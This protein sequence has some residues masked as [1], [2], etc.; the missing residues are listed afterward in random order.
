MSTS[1]KIYGSR[2]YPFKTS[3][4]EGKRD[5][6]EYYTL[7]NEKTQRLEVKDK[8]LTAAN[9]R[10]VGYYDLSV[11]PPKFVRSSTFFARFDDKKE[12]EFFSSEDGLKQAQTAAIQGG[13]KEQVKDAG[14][15][16]TV[17]RKQMEDIVKTGSTN[18]DPNDANQVA[19]IIEQEKEEILG[20]VGRKNFGNLRYPYKTMSDD[21]DA[22]K[23][24][25]LEFT[26][27]SF[28]SKTPGVLQDRERKTV[29]QKQILG[30]VT[31]PIPG[32]I[33]DQNSVGWSAG[34]LNPAQ[35]LGAQAT[36][37]LLGDGDTKVGDIIKGVADTAS[38]PGVKDTAIE[39]LAGAATGT[40][41]QL[42]Q[43]QQGAVFNP[44]VELLFNKPNLRSFNFQFN[45]SPR[46]AGESREVK[47]IIRLFKQGMS[48]RKTQ[49]GVFLK[50]PLIFQI[51]YI[52]NAT[53]LNRFKEAALTN[54][55]V[56]YTPN[57]SY[58]TFRDGTMTQYK[59]TM[60]YQELD[61]I[62]SSDYD[63]L[64]DSEFEFNGSGSLANPN[65]ADSA[66]IGF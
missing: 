38:L 18:I 53:N 2:K 48:V 50:S 22:I 20:A 47:K 61:P 13:I 16:P 35:A 5:N 17:A 34:E 41:Q 29:E 14:V 55:A 39:A 40:N 59:I 19:Q 31:L 64:D 46:N 9:D 49:R 66:G 6:F 23:F 25:L 30:S 45:L 27:R 57:G 8:G 63:E 43:R 36:I 24:A 54:F 62:F 21:Q 10:S 44:N 28:D 1:D 33:R 52:N 15:N 3:G 51:T 42:I 32:G 7:V 58:S 65:T 56:D 12:L 60:S 37:S 4:Q 26:P 11:K